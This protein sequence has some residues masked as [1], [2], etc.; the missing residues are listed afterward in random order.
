MSQRGQRITTGL[1]DKKLVIILAV[2]LGSFRRKRNESRLMEELGIE[3]KPTLPNPLGNDRVIVKLK[4]PGL[5]RTQNKYAMN[6]TDSI[7]PSPSLYF[8]Q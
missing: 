6:D 1:C 8:G 5:A 3:S 4:L 7:A 2:V